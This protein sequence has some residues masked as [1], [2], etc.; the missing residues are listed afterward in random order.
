MGQTTKYSAVN[1]LPERKVDAEK[2]SHMP[3]DGEISSAVLAIE[4]RGIRVIR[5]KSGEAALDKI[6]D[7]RLGY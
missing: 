3:S 1:L 7:N 2:W 6:K 4:G 5:E